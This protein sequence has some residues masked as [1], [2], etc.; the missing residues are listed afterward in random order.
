MSAGLV[1]CYALPAVAQLPGNPLFPSLSKA[2]SGPPP[3]VELPDPV[4]NFG[5]V[6]NG[7]PV[8]HIFTIKN[9]GE[10]TLIIGDVMTSC[11]CTAAKPTKTRLAPGEEAQI[12]VTLDTRVERGKVARTITA[13]TNDP[14]HPKAVMTIKGDVRILVDATPGEVAFGNVRH[15]VGASRRVL[16]SD[17]GAKKD[18][19][20]GPISNSSPYIKVTEAARHDGKPGAALDVALLKAAPI[21]GLVDTVRVATNRGSLEIPVFGMVSGDLMVKPAQISFGI[22]PHRQGVIRIVRLTNRS[23]RTVRVLGVSSSNQSVRAEVEP[24]TPGKEYK[25]TL[26]LRKDTPDGQLR[27]Q[28]AIHTDDPQQATLT[29]PYYAIVGSFQG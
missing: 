6:I 26:V 25:I 7:K 9:G 3:K 18:F 19:K 8:K 1:L 29:V 2:P 12:A 16:I 11:G 4:Y 20:I 17:L 15:G 28:L 24:V 27:G 23:K 22:V 13:L 5:T 21:G 10:G 14:K